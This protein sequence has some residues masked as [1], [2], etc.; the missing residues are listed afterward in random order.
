MRFFFRV[1][2]FSTYQRAACNKVSTVVLPR[3]SVSLSVCL[4]VCM[5]APRVFVFTLG[6]RNPADAGPGLL[7]R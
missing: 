3:N 4:S 5:S 6:Y 2:T 1:E 7:P